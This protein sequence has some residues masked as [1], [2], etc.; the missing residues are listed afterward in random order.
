M[1]DS[2]GA[3]ESWPRTIAEAARALREGWVTSA[4]LVERCLG[5]IEQMEPSLKACV[6]VMDE[7]AHE[8]AAEADA[9]L[10]SGRDR[11]PLLGIPLGIK[12]LIE[13]KG[14]RTTAGSRVLEDWVPDQDATVVTRLLAAGAIPLCKTNT[15]EFAFGT[16]TPPT[17]NPWDLARSPGGSS[18]GSAA[19]LAAGE[20]FG[21]LGTDTGG[22]VRIPASW[23][24]VTGLKPTFGLVSRAGI[25]PLSWSYDHA[26][27]L[28]R[29]VEDCALL[30]DALAGHDPLDPDSVDVPLL[31]YASALGA[32]RS[33]EEALRG[34]RIGVPAS[35]FFAQIDAEVEA[36]VRAALDRLAS[37]G[38]TLV[39][40]PMPDI[41]NDELFD[42]GYRAVQ[43]PEAYTYH[44]DQGWLEQCADR[45]APEVLANIRAG[46][47][48][49]AADYIRAQRLRQRL[50][51]EMRGVLGG[52]DLLATP[53][54]PIPAATS[55]E[56]AAGLKVDGK[57]ITGTTMRCT[58]PFDLTGQPALSIPC[59]F[60]ANGLPIGL[61]LVARHF[62]E[63]TLLRVGHAYQRTTEWHA[64][65]PD[66]TSA[67]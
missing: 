64:R 67:G 38:A 17:A 59:G 9:V 14:A 31:D 5:R 35:Y 8:R 4:G 54:V 25:V 13:T 42:K 22:S 63:P 65:R 12:D 56:F 53:T 36:A 26:G 20:F 2:T 41:L 47:D 15:H 33:P 62:G 28:A 32:A 48:Y 52:I 46:A 27:P 57:P 55:A 58:F 66:V 23:C 24:G 21:A 40:V 6:T 3:G 1:G 51:E 16:M 44:S 61:Q 30:L 18:G 45:Y 19:G 50:T 34:T 7:A 10:A 60:T 11:R 43:K 37:L 49:S 39:E 29:T